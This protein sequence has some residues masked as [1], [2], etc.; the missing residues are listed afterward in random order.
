MPEVTAAGRTRPRGVGRPCPHLGFAL[1]TLRE[2][3]CVFSPQS[4]ELGSSNPRTLTVLRCQGTASSTV[5]G[6]ITRPRESRHFWR[7]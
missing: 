2:Q 6:T 1:W 5:T 4:V 7:V 3:I